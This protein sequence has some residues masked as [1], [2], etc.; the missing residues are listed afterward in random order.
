V[1]NRKHRRM[2]R[3]LAVGAILAVCSG[4]SIFPG[5]QEFDETALSADMIREMEQTLKQGKI[6]SATVALVHGERIVWTGALGYTNLWARTKAVPESVY[7]IGSTFKT[8]SM[9]ALLGLMEQGK[10]RLD[11]PVGGYLEDIGIQ[12]DD[13]DNPVTFRHLLT[14]TSGLPAD[15]GPHAV[16]GNTVP[17]P[18]EDYLKKSLRLTHP[19][20]TKTVYSNTAYTLVAYLVEKLSGTSYK[21]YIRKNIFEPMGM[22]DTDFEPR[23]D[24]EERLALPYVVDPKSG[25]LVPTTRTKANVWPAGIVYGTVLD[26]AK[27]LIANLNH[28]V[29]QGRRFISEETFQDVMTRQYDQFAG[30]ISAGWLNPTTGFGLTWWISLREGDTLFAHSGSVSGFTAFMVGNLDKKTGFAVLTN[31]NRAHKHLFELAVKA[32]DLIEKHRR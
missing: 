24:M 12:G 13:P 20:L 8:M 30:P 29:Y 21:R 17:P 27:W 26:Q 23:P 25:R 32:L 15:F 9:Y 3:S 28:G 5:G 22:R 31:G 14:H 18:L 19:P 11:D 1:G 10:F 7:L 6:P 4:A 16:W 2:L